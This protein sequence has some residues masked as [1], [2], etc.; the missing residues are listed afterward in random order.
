[1][2]SSTSGGSSGGSGR[3]PL[4]IRSAPRT[5]KAP[6]AS[7]GTGTTKKVMT[8][9]NILA[10]AFSATPRRVD[11]PLAAIARGS[12][13]DEPLGYETTTIRGETRTT[14][15]GVSTAPLEMQLGAADAPRRVAIKQVTEQLAGDTLANIPGTAGAVLGVV[16][17]KNLENQIKQLREGGT[18]VFDT[19]TGKTVGVVNKAGQY[20]G[21]TAFQAAAL[22]AGKGDSIEL[23]GTDVLEEARLVSKEDKQPTQIIAEEQEAAAKAA[24]ALGAAG[25]GRGTRGKRFGA[26]GTILEGTGAL[27]D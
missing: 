25:R 12:A 16:S 9:D 6:V 8:T 18:P 10:K 15:G 20:S 19:D 22:K 5:G 21:D 24:T 4:T 1:M 3:Q 13:P 27:Y 17:K 14:R 23:S 11:T 2:S 26:G 7:L